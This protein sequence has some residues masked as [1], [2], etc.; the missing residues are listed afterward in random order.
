MILGY[1]K[2]TAD[3]RPFPM[4]E[5]LR[6]VAEGRVPT[7][8]MIARQRARREAAIAEAK[9]SLAEHG[10]APFRRAADTSKFDENSRR[11]RLAKLGCADGRPEWSTAAHEAGHAVAAHFAGLTCGKASVTPTHDGTSIVLGS[12]TAAIDRL[13]P[14]AAAMLLIAGPM[15]ERK[16]TTGR[17]EFVEVGGS[18]KAM[19]AELANKHGRKAIESGLSDAKWLLNRYWPAID[20]LARE[21]V[22]DR[23]VGG[24]RI[25]AICSKH[26]R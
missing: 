21:L 20:E 15:A 10:T 22:T 26:I 7:P 23:T 14:N 2:H 18:D 5:V 17:L 8:A 12:V 4:S 16:A 13:K 25:A 1:P 24:D 19:L 11:V 6:E 3:G 9:R